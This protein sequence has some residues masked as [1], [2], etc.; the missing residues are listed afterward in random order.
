VRQSSVIAH[1]PADGRQAL[2]S[3]D[4]ASMILTLHSKKTANIA[5]VAKIST[6][7]KEANRITVLRFLTP[8]RI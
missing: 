3:Q 1:K 7:S 2:G 8:R 5:I 6:F 4:H